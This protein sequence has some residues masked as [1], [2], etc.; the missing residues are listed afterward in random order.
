MRSSCITYQQVCQTVTRVHVQTVDTYQKKRHKL[1]VFL[2]PKFDVSLLVFLVIGIQ[3]FPL[4]SQ[5]FASFSPT[6]LSF[7]QFL[8]SFCSR[9]L[10]FCS[11]FFCHFQN[12]KPFFPP[13]YCYVHFC[14]LF[15]ILGGAFFWSF[16]FH[17]HTLSLFIF[18]NFFSP[19][20][21]F[22][23][24]SSNF[25]LIFFNFLCHIVF[26]C[27]SHVICCQSCRRICAHIQVEPSHVQA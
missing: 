18:G 14:R 16:Y 19:K 26:P 2:P 21:F 7:L 11:I 17:A 27:P 3:F 6:Y 13:S 10:T 24:S 22:P 1:Y 9:F 25:F 12:L 5:F 8:K 4:S 23:F 15:L 20:F